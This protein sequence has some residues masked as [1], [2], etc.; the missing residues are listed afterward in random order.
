MGAA[1]FPQSNIALVWLHAAVHTYI[2]LVFVTLSYGNSIS[3]ISN[4]Q[5]RYLS[6]IYLRSTALHVARLWAWKSGVFNRTGCQRAS[7]F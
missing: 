2:V 1:F 4:L 3:F 7:S 6:S 5:I